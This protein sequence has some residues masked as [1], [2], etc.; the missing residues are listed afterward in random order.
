MSEIVELDDFRHSWRTARAD[1]ITCKHTWQA[2]FP[3]GCELGLE[4]PQCGRMHGWAQIPENANKEGTMRVLTWCAK[5]NIG[6]YA[7][8][9]R[10]G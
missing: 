5:N 8:E 10:E 9:P 4:C 1:C 3:D 6:P 2:V 7:D